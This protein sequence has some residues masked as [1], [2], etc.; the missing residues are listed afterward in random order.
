MPCLF[1]ACREA[2]DGP[3]LITRPPCVGRFAGEKVP[4]GSTPARVLCPVDSFE[5]PGA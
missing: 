2:L 1:S 5:N 4:S 3:L